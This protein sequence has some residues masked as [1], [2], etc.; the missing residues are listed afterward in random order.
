MTLVGLA[1]HV[2]IRWI[3]SAEMCV[4]MYILGYQ[5]LKHIQIQLYNIWIEFP[6]THIAPT[7]YRKCIQVSSTKIERDED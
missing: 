1:A 4:L 6:P 5:H 3:D 2:H 7:S